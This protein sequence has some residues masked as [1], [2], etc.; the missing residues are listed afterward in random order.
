M[1]IDLSYNPF[2]ATNE[3]LLLLAWIGGITHIR[4][5]QIKIWRN[6]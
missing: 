3:K 5:M 6:A 4:S 1:T 2:I